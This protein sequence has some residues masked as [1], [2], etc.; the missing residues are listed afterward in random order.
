MDFE[1]YLRANLPIVESFHP[2]YQKALKEMMLCGGK[3]FRPA[4]VFAAC[5]GIAPELVESSFPAALAVE[6]LHTYSLIHDDLPAMD[7]ADLRRGRATLHKTY[8]EVTAILVGDALNTHSFYVIASSSLPDQTKTALIETL[9]FNGGAGGMV[10]GQAL[11]CHFEG[12]KLPLDRLEFI[13]IHKTAMLIAASLKMGAIVARAAEALR[14]ELYDL[15]LKIG[16]F[17]QIRD[18]IIDATED[19]KSAGKSV[20]Q[21]DG[22][23]SYV[24]LLGLEGAQE[25]LDRSAE[26]IRDKTRS[27]PCDLRATVSN[28]LKGYL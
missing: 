26:E 12:V 24:T 19:E 5:A 23:N 21:D 15:G 1:N 10:L 9:S 3:R 16:L 20:H 2:H 13:H 8:D 22:K 27:L 6:M 14:G 25:R 17:F 11:D 7:D 28:A 4:L 18:D